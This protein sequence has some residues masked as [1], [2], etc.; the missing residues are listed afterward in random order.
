MPKKIDLDK[1]HAQK[2]ILLFSKLLFS[3]R[4]YSLTELSKMLNCSKQTIQR[5]VDHINSSYS[6]IIIEEIVGNRKYYSIAKLPQRLPMV[7]MSESEYQ[8]LQMCK[9]FTENLLGKDLFDEATR[10]L[11]KSRA[12][13]SK[14]KGPSSPNHFS[15][16]RPGSI[17]YTPHQET[18]RTIIDALD[19]RGVCK[20]TYHSPDRKH[21]KTFE[22]KPLKLFSYDH[23]LYLHA[24][25]AL[26]KGEKYQQPKYDPLLAVHRIKNIEITD[27]KYEFPIDYDFDKS[28]NKSFGIIEAES[29]QV[30]VLFNGFAAAYVAERIWSEDQTIE[31]KEDG[32]VKLVFTTSSIPEVTAWILSFDKEATVLEP[33]WLRDKIKGLIRVMQRNY[34]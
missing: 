26:S 22:I 19:K 25:K 2:V 6:I 11:E 9:A 20:I 21:P 32:S 14:P 10:A 33:Q 28:F 12:L 13:V 1:T 5:I 17:D 31:K 34:K 7:S 16:L 3:N 24:R 18:I 4:S 8:T 15:T 30:A 27:K 23:G 29:F